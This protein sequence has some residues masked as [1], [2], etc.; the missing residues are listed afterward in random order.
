MFGEIFTFTDTQYIDIGLKW[1]QILLKCVKK[2]IPIT[3][4]SR[5]PE[6]DSDPHII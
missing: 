6:A 1:Q 4:N 3:P 5:V 2:D